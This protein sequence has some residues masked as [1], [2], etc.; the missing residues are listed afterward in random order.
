MSDTIDTAA[1]QKQASISLSDLESILTE[2]SGAKP[3]REPSITNGGTAYDDYRRYGSFLSSD[4][5]KD[6]FNFVLDESY[7]LMGLGT[8]RNVL[9]NFL[10][11]LDR[12]GTAMVPLNTMNYG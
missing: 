10:S 5:L 4:A 12:H 1:L 7:R 6:Y 3:L 11:R 9:Q 2:T 8:S